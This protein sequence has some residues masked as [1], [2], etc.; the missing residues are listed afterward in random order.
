VRMSV[1]NLSRPSSGAWLRDIS[2]HEGADRIT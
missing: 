1:I 2:G